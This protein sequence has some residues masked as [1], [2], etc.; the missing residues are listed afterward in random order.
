MKLTLDLTGT[1]LALLYIMT[2]NKDA[3]EILKEANA[4]YRKHNPPVRPYRRK[5]KKQ[6]QERGNK[7]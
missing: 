2:G 4:E 6:E 3:G 5:A 1:E 7:E